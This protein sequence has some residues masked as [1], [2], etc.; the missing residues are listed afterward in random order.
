[1]QQDERSLMEYI[2]DESS[3]T[4]SPMTGFQLNT[5]PISIA[6]ARLDALYEEY[7]TGF[8]HGAYGDQTA[9]KIAE[10]HTRSE[11]VGLEKVRTEIMNQVQTHLDSRANQSNG[12]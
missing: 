5:T 1:M 11:Q 9:A 2:Y 12:V 3:Y 7:Y 4:P 6:M 10:L 8:T